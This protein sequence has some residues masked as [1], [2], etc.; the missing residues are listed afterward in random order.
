MAG[1]GGETAGIRGAAPMTASM[2]SDKEKRLADFIRAARA[3]AEEGLNSLPPGQSM[4]IDDAMR[5][6]A[7]LCLVHVLSSGTVIGALHQ[8][9]PDSDPVTLF[10]IE[11]EEISH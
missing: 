8:N 7:E 4:V 1:G 2:S 10:R 5:R 9:H 3:L 6:G 11:M